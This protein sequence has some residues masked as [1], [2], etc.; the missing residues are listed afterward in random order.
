MATVAPR[1]IAPSERLRGHLAMA[2]FALLI[3][4]SFS[5]GSR[6]APHIGAG[7]LNAVRFFFGF[8]A[9]G[10]IAWV[11]TPVEARASL[12]RPKSVW[13]FL[14]LG[15]LMSVYFVMMFVALKSTSPVSTGAMLTLMPLISAGLGV[16][17]LRQTLSPVVLGSLLLAAAGAIW[18]IF[19]GDVN[20]I[21]AFDIGKGEIIFFIGVTAHATYNVLV[22]KF[23]RGEPVISFTFWT[24]AATTL[25]LIVYATP[26][27][28]STHWLKLP[29]IVWACIVYLSIFTTAATYFLLQYA[30]MRI[31]AAKAVAYFLLTPTYVIL[32]EGLVGGGW[33][34]PAVFA[35]ALVTLLGLAILVISPDV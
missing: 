9:M 34:R 3:A 31:P 28:L 18:V 35:G 14:I 32:I 6:A 2:L 24:L 25:I 8:I 17:V 13:R 23:N 21:L 11:L 5:I 10:V 29:A 20:A 7:A 4:V 33:A 19:R 27:L 22:R 26:E 12:L 16:L 30:V 15:S 1:L